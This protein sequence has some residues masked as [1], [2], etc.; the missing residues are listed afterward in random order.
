MPRT[1]KPVLVGLDL[2]ASRARA[3]SGATDSQP[4]A[5]LLEGT[6]E[7]LPVALSLEDRQ[8][9]VGSPGLSLCR[10]LPH[11]A[12]LDFLGCL[13]TDRQWFSGRRRL[14]AAGALGS[15]LDHLRLR[16]SPHS[17]NRL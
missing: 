11:L 5:L 8:V 3:V 10:R 15:V 17:V 1:G 6:S 14:D 4:L 9:E 12:C 13:G 16:L 7:E 2:N